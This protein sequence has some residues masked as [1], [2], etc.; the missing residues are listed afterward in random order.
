[1][2]ISSAHRLNIIYLYDKYF[3]IKLLLTFLISIVVMTYIKL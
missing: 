3:V 2:G 1:M